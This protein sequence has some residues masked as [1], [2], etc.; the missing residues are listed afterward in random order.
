MIYRNTS[1][2][3]WAPAHFLLYVL[4]LATN[5]S[6]KRALQRDKNTSICYGGDKIPTNE[7]SYLWK[8]NGSVHHDMVRP[9]LHRWFRSVLQYVTAM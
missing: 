7:P 4:P 8:C 1:G 6:V 9:R 3:S 5:A 2:V